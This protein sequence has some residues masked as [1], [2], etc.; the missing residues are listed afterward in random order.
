MD[1]TNLTIVLCLKEGENIRVY[2]R[3][4]NHAGEKLSLQSDN[5]DFA[6][7]PR[8]GWEF[9]LKKGCYQNNLLKDPIAHN[10]KND[11]IVFEK[12]KSIP[13]IDG[14]SNKKKFSFELINHACL[15]FLGDPSLLLLIPG[16]LAAHFLLAGGAVCRGDQIGQKLLT[17]AILFISVI[18]TRTTF[19]STPFQK[20]DRT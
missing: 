9:S 16:L 17:N 8:H 6:R 2:D 18:I 13:Y 5:I 12:I 14:N 10:I 1:Q 19:T 3:I 4:C 20:S 15:L 11:K 7:C